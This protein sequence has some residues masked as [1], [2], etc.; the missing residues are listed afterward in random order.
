MSVSQISFDGQQYKFSVGK[1]VYRCPDMPSLEEIRQE[2]IKQK[3]R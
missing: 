3:V 1:C 2:I